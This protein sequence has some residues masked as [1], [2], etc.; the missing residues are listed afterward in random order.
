M[1][2]VSEDTVDALE[3]LAE[4]NDVEFD[5]VRE[6]FKEKYE[7]VGDKAVGEVS[8]EKLEQL[9]LRATRTAE[10]SDSR[11]PT[12]G[13]EM[14]TVGGSV[15][16]WNNGDTFVGKALVD[17]EPD[18]DEGRNF[19][20]T[21]IIDGS[22]VSLGEVVDAFGDVGN[23]VSGEFSVSEAHTDKFRVLNSSEDTELNVQKPDD[24]GP[25]IEEIR[26]VVPETTIR[27]ITDNLSQTERTD[28]GDV[29]PASFGV[30]IRRMTVDIYDGYKNPSEGNGTYTVRD[31]TV[32]DED[33]IVESPV[34]DSDNAGENAT[35]GLTCWADPSM[36]EYGTGSVV[37]MFG[38]VSKNEDGIASMNV[39][40]IVPIM[41]EGEF[42][43]YEDNSSDEAPER[44][45][46]SSNVDRTSI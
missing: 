17:L 13:V 29:Y 27:D 24:R 2:E 9:A 35:P 32:F 33:D 18:T 36:M 15:R 8:D 28:D 38:T 37:E 45:Q 23:I 34:F 10:L 25:M 44:E 46:T 21:V 39:D 43:G 1:V 42:D 40:G 11:V 26:N 3:T 22:D 31:D 7:E 12:N 16:N 20:S 14:L 5:A 19:L 6:T 30:D 41:V 4:D